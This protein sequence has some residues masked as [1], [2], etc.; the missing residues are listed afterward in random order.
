M[1]LW[2]VCLLAS[3]T[4]LRG[5]ETA[6][7]ESVL[8]A[9]AAAVD[10]TP[11]QL[12]VI[13]CGGFLE[14]TADRVQDSLHARALVLDNG[15]TRLGIVVVDTLMMPRELID[16]AKSL[17]EQSTGIPADHL[18]VSAT[19]THSA[20]SV[21]ACLGSRV[22]ETYARGFAERVAQSVSLAAEA[23]QPARIGWA[24]VRDEVHN[25]CRRWIFRPD[26]MAT[27]PFGQTNVRAHMHPGYESPNHVG[28][29][30]PADPDL[31]VLAVQTRD[32]QPLAV[33]AN[34]ALH[35]FGWEP[36][37]SDFCGRFGDTLAPLIGAARRE[38]PFVGLMSQGTSGDSMWMDYSRPAL[39]LSLQDYTDAVVQSALQAYRQIEYRDWVP[40]DMAETTLTLRRRTPDAERLAWA[41]NIL[42]E[43][44]DGLPRN[45]QEVY[46]REQL[47]LHERPEVELKL[48]AL[49]I[50]ELGITAI[51]NEVF[52]ITG[53]KIK[54]FSP[55][56]PTF[57]IELANGAEGYIPPPE[58][59]QLGGYTTWPARTAGLEVQAEPAIV[60]T[61]LSLLEKVSARPR[62]APAAETTAYSA[63]ILASKP[64]AYWRLAEMAGSQTAD[65][66][67]K[68]SA[69]LE[70]GYALYLP[71]PE[72]A[73]ISA[74]PRGN[75][76]VH[77]AGGRLRSQLD[78]VGDTYAVEFW[79]WNGLPHDAR[80]VSGYLFSRGADG[81]KRAPGDHLG[82][83]GTHESNLSG[84]LFFY[85]GDERKQLLAGKTPLQLRTWYHVVLM[86]E[87]ASVRVY[88]NGAE[89]PE[90][91]GEAERGYPAGVTQFFFA[92]RNDR[93]FS[94]EGK[95]D[96]IAVY[97]RVLPPREVAAH[98]ATI[99]SAD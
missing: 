8:R 80:P 32:G 10:I 56:Q 15:T 77:F 75:R 94:L 44:G 55:L 22:D 3:A 29:A 31:S 13:V 54:R 73:G 36:V 7:A 63:A 93:L 97:S 27:D 35:Y 23:L 82:I 18:L 81:A 17:T 92:G 52:G 72:G 66:T 85:N 86:R 14:R 87:G 47:F 11:Q 33:L 19:H 51:P 25:H 78:D 61:M 71:G 59:H 45:Q 41:R 99:A 40:L 9:G 43:L 38:P 65:A 68:H 34:Y 91:T 6:P 5:A 1:T 90:I 16:R 37:S 74:D 89:E 53:L 4:G 98:F 83:G 28:P 12:P 39:K 62:R 21:M 96:E 58:Q 60:E 2:S 79:F 48:Q 57:N 46:A 50:G 64:V 76:A 95:L 26:R 24:V 42:Q 20:P 70:P 84:R 30:G 88:L 69:D 49:R 67:G